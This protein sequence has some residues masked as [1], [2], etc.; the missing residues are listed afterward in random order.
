MVH[1]SVIEKIKL[2]AVK[3]VLEKKERRGNSYLHWWSLSLM[4]VEERALVAVA[5]NSVCG[6]RYPLAQ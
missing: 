2:L 4:T 6:L 1:S 3:M 5:H